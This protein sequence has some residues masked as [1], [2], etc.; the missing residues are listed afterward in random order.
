[1]RTLIRRVEHAR[2][3]MVFEGASRTLAPCLLALC[4]L[5]L[6]LLV[7]LPHAVMRAQ[8]FSEHA[9]PFTLTGSLITAGEHYDIPGLD[10]H[11]PK[12]TARLYFNPTL[13]IYGLQLPFSFILS[14]QERSFNQ[15]FNQF[16]VSPT[17]R[18]LTLH[19]G[20][21]SL[22]YSEFTL[23][24][25]VLYGGGAEVNTERFRA[26]AIYGRIRR[27]VEEDTV[28][29]V[30]AAYQRM[31]VATSVGVGDKDTYLDLNVLY[32]WDD[33]TSLTTPRVLSE[34][35]PMEN[36]VGGLNGRL[37]LFAGRVVLDAEF[38]GSFMT[39]DTDQPE[40]EN[41]DV[42]T[43]LITETRYSSRL[44]Y[45]W[46]G[47]ASYNADLWALRLEYARVEPEY[48][49]MG[50]IH[51][52]NDYEDV[53]IKPQFRLA[54]GSLRAA[55]SI[56]WRHDN[57][58]D[59]RQ[60]TTNRVIG[61]ANLNWSPSPLFN[62]D[63]S[64]SNYSM[65]SAAGSIPVN[66]ST[67]LDNVSASWSLSPRLAITGDRTQHFL[68]LLLSRQVFAD[69]NLLTG[70]TSDNDVLT[71]L[72]GYNLGFATGYGFSA[73]FLFTEVHTA[74][75]TNIVRGLTVESS[76]AFF[77]NALNASLSYAINF[78]RAS[79]ESATDT[80]HLVTLNTRYRLSRFDTI[81]FRYQ[82]NTYHAV[83]PARRSYAGSIVR[84]QYNRGFSF[85]TN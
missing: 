57:L 35:R 48:E 50:A 75:V 74:F 11:R 1:M 33:S 18:W 45:A 21:R 29:G 34:I 70:A 30:L 8:D 53:T 12:N 4:L 38:A 14:T 40:V 82:Y 72:L 77:D 25:A 59:D 69:E 49:T 41:D 22:R 7:L 80:Q 46:R 84:L 5:A 65:S 83:D 13:S 78:T 55:G 54:D 3:C 26:R 60:Y 63:G 10:T 85:G 20:Y 81:E 43:P 58:F 27:A 79:S 47:G 6:C 9:Q 73:S 24:D 23:N 52:Q 32:G 42:P 37:P 36:V 19:A 28:T 44:C 15:P 71:A 61:S 68:M 56:G 67:R 31:G 39:R 2:R 51:T 76:R 17:Y 62:V 64:Y 66:D 16:G